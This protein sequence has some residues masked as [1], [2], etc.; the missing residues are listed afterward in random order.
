MNSEK[1]IERHITNV[2]VHPDFNII[3][4]A[5]YNDV[6]ILTLGKA[7]VF[8]DNVRPVCLPEVALA[9]ADHLTGV[10][11]TVSGWGKTDSSTGTSETLKTAE[12]RIYN[13]RY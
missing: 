5:A 12:L 9:E 8:S 1:W 7:V 3:P 6:A 11:V 13:Q 2:S 10:A 4:S